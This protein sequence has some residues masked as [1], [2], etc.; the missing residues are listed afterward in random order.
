MKG[1]MPC[2]QMLA[3]LLQVEHQTSNAVLQMRVS[4]L[5]HSCEYVSV[6]P[7]SPR[8]PPPAPRPAAAASLA[9]QRRLEVSP[10]VAHLPGPNR[11]GLRQ[12]DDRPAGGADRD[13]R[14]GA[15]GRA[16][17][18]ERACQHC[19]LCPLV[20]TPPLHLFATKSA[21][22]SDH[23]QGWLSTALLTLF[24]C[25][26]ILLLHHPPQVRWAACQ[27]LGQMCTDLGPDIQEGHHAAIL[28]ALMAAMDDFNNPR[29]QVRRAAQR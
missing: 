29:V 27:A 24:S 9:V 15:G 4:A 8:P 26:T 13:V 19:C 20:N 25:P 28:P 2:V 3:M 5:Q 10:R 14:Q 17:Q 11:R 23:T 6:P 7:Q 1:D 22:A 16:P 12:G 21:T 18:G